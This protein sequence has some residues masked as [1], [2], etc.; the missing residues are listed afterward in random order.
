MKKFLMLLCAATMVFGMVGVAGAI[1]ITDTYN[2][3]H[4]LLRSWSRDSKTWEHNINDDGFIQ[5]TH[6]VTSAAITLWLQDDGGCWDFWEVASLNIGT[7]RFRWEVDT[8]EISFNVASLISLT[9]TGT[10]NATLTATWGDFYFNS[11][12]LRADV[13][14]PSGDDGGG[15]APVPE[16]STMLLMGTGLLGLVAYGRKRYNRKV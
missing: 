13:I 2:A 4:T 8:G 5:G 6:E 3:G 15:T 16:P 10:I 14:D 11:A 12:T 7:N 9:A 1:T